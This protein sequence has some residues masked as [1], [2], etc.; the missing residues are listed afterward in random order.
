MV[1]LTPKFTLLA[2]ALS[3]LAAVSMLPAPADAA[4]LVLKEPEGLLAARH[5]DREKSVVA[6]AAAADDQ[7]GDADA[8]DGEPT[9]S[10]SG[11]EKGK[12]GEKKK[13][14]KSKDKA[15]T[16]G[17]DAPAREHKP[18][19]PLPAAMEKMGKKGHGKKEREKLDARDGKQKHM[20]IS[21]RLLRSAVCHYRS[22]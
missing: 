11:K 3:S 2:T 10:R 13:K 18:T 7:G 22:G 15:K 6:A 5:S 8:G 12:A 19:V 9:P 21:V 1:R 4:V 20:K 17:K 14:T 16:G